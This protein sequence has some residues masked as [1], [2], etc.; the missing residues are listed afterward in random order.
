MTDKTISPLRRRMIEDMTVR[1]FSPATQ[2]GYIRAVMVFTAFL[3]RSPDQAGAEDVRRYQLHM[4]SSEASA[5][6]MNAAVSALRFFFGVTLRR[7]DAQVGM[8]IALYATTQANRPAP[9]VAG[10][11]E[12]KLRELSHYRRQLV[13]ERVRLTNQMSHLENPELRQISDRRLAL[14]NGSLKHVERMI[15]GAIDAE[16]ELARR[17]AI[18]GSVGGVGAVSVHA[19]LA[20]M[21]ELGRIGHKQAAALLGVAPMA[22]DSGNQSGRRF[23][24]GGAL[25]CAL[26]ALHGRPCRGASARRPPGLP[27]TPDHHGKVQQA[28][29]HRRHAQ[30]DRVDQH[31]AATRPALA[32][33]RP[34]RKHSCLTKG[35]VEPAGP[36][37]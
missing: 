15:Q 33:D 4:R 26:R 19:L 35:E 1:G 21:P 16:P 10:P 11:A 36:K 27:P 25:A 8:T 14:V 13:T 34:M 18:V 22:N 6:T 29:P 23:I 7:G 31:P 9:P 28:G 2:R 3:G 17:A 32:A 37:P 20:D 12:E 5:T 24:M 30:D